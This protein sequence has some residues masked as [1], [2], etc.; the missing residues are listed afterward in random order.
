MRADINLAIL[1]DFN[2]SLQIDLNISLPPIYSELRT[3]MHM[4]IEGDK[5][6]QSY[7]SV[8]FVHPGV[9][10]ARIKKNKLLLISN[11]TGKD[12]KN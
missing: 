6:E 3:H 2:I 1:I 7:V 5:P 10:L 11:K 4:H 9:Y 8:L 12:W